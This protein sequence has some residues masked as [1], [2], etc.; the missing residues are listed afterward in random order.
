MY[1]SCKAAHTGS[2]WYYHKKSILNVFCVGVLR[3]KQRN[4][5]TRWNLKR[6]CLQH[7]SNK[8]FFYKRD[9]LNLIHNWEKVKMLSWEGHYNKTASLS[10]FFTMYM[11]SRS[12]IKALRRQCWDIYMPCPWPM[13]LTYQLELDISREESSAVQKS[14]HRLNIYTFKMCCKLQIWHW[15][16]LAYWL[17]PQC[18]ISGTP[19]RCVYKWGYDLSKQT[20]MLHAFWK[21][22]WSRTESQFNNSLHDFCIWSFYTWI[23]ILLIDILPLDL[24]DK[25]HVKYQNY[26]TGRVRDMG[27]MGCS[28]LVTLHLLHNYS[29]ASSLFLI[30]SNLVLYKPPF[31]ICVVLADITGIRAPT[32]PTLWT[33]TVMVPAGKRAEC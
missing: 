29:H 19:W 26:Y 13:T 33:Q 16:N 24:H 15:S 14:P 2:H 17:I 23:R 9:V 25:I 28:K 4:K 5:D 31:C 1:E 11:F 12:I 7:C 22:L 20:S 6:P 30:F 27:D 21:R 8:Q 32:F 10:F 18:P 3:N